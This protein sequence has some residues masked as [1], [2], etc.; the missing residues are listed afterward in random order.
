MV[1][2]RLATGTRLLSLTLLFGA[3]F[4]FPAGWT[5]DQPAELSLVG[6]A[7]AF[8]T[9]V[10]VGLEKR[11]WPLTPA[12]V[13]LVALVG[14]VALGLG[15]TVDQQAS[16][17]FLASWTS[18]LTAFF[19][20]ATLREPTDWNVGV[21]GLTLGLGASCLYGL[22]TVGEERVVKA[23]FT[24][25]DCYSVLPLTMVFLALSQWGR[26]RKLTGLANIAL[27]GLACVTLFFTG[28]RASL[29]GL[30][31][32]LVLLTWLEAKPPKGEFRLSWIAWSVPAFGIGLL[33]ATF[34]F[35]EAFRKVFRLLE[36][37]ESIGLQAR[38]EVLMAGPKL[39]WERPLLGFGPGT[40]PF[41]YQRVRSDAL[42]QEGFM[43]VAHNDYL[44]ILVDC[45]FP[46]L[47]LFLVVV[48]ALW[49]STFRLARQGSLRAITL[50][51][52][53][54]ALLI[55]LV[56]NFAL[57]V[58]ADWVVFLGFGGLLYSVGL[59]GESRQVPAWVISL[60]LVGCGAY[61]LAYGWSGLQVKRA[62]EQ[63]ET[64]SETLR[65]EQA[66]AALEKALSYQPYR[67]DLLRRR[68]ELA[69]RLAAW[70]ESDAPLE[71]SRAFLLQAHGASPFDLDVLAA[72]AQTEQRLG[73]L[74]AGES[75]WLQAIET[76]PYQWSLKRGL[77]VNLLLQD[78]LDDAVSLLSDVREPEFADEHGHLLA[79]LE[80][81]EP[82]QGLA[83]ASQL[84]SRR[85]YSPKDVR[86]LLDSALAASKQDRPYR[87]FL[88]LYLQTFPDDLC[89]RLEWALLLEPRQR[90]GELKRIVDAETSSREQ[91]ACQSQAL[92]SW[93]RLAQTLGADLKPVIETL[94]WRLDDTP[95]DTALRILISELYE[96]LD[97]PAS[98]RAVLR[99]GLN[100]DSSGKLTVALGDLFD[101]GGHHEIALTYLEEALARDPGNGYLQ[102]RVETLRRIVYQE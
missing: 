71:Q 30:V 94:E 50:L 78:R 39:A 24:N 93:G 41:A 48:A 36:G 47:L 32:G 13:A 19:L 44:Q 63:A 102:Q 72:L 101:R 98:A 86:R 23:N 61:L 87:S 58:P 56:F 67:T 52:G 46:A 29:V 96:D 37:G 92:L 4:I 99:E 45:G 70:D 88:E 11:D 8:L 35:V 85:A 84:V 42:R 43:N 59:N 20:L 54:T 62:V 77:L 5:A 21:L 49:L 2:Q 15:S 16:R 7:V 75:R 79:V 22:A 97:E 83:L 34:R 100:G 80:E 18:G 55:Y 74:K 10:L 1:G 91:R 26:H 64:Y 89:Q 14:W 17:L 3:V 40:F 6:G 51:A 9:A 82:G 33:L 81:A 28:C 57:P 27:A 60:V 25:P 68:A 66:D 12:L 69:T 53:W 31:V 76:A 65:W 95:R 73:N 38:W 90:L